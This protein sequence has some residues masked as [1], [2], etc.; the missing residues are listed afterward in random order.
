MVRIGIISDTHGSKNNLNIIYNAFKTVDFFIHAGDHWQDGYYLQKKFKVPVVAVKGNCDL[1]PF[2][3]EMVFELKNKRFYLT[4]GH[5]YRVKYGL[6]NLYYRAQEC[7]A[8]YCIFGHTHEP[9]VTLV[10]NI[11]FLN[12]GS[13]TFPRGVTKY[14]G[15]MLEYKY[16]DFHPYL[17]EV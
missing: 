12:P 1:R 15:I 16:N 7:K 3:Q 11:T 9:L 14:L 10:D 5:H 4:H 8:D 6:K 13:L 2:P 17:L